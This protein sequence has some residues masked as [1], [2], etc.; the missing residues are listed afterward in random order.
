MPEG[1]SIFQGATASAKAQRWCVRNS[2][3]NQP[4]EEGGEVT[5]LLS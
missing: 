5:S 3:W 4:G 1:K 2:W